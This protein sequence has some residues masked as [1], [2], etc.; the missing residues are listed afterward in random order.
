MCV[1]RERDWAL[2]YKATNMADEKDDCGKVTQKQRGRSRE[3]MRYSNPYRFPA[4]RRQKGNQYKSKQPSTGTCNDLKQSDV[5]ELIPEQP[6]VHPLCSHGDVAELFLAETNRMMLDEDCSY[7]QA[8]DMDRSSDFASEDE[9]NSRISGDEFELLDFADSDDTFEQFVKDED[10]CSDFFSDC[11]DP[12]EIDSECIP[13][14]CEAESDEGLYSG[15]PITSSSSVVLLLSFVFKH[16]LTCEAFNDL[17]A[18]IEA[19]CPR[20]NNCKTTVNKLFQF[21]SQAKGNVV[22]H[23]FCSF[24]KAYFGKDVKGNCNICGKS[25]QNNGGFF[26]EVPIVNQ[27]LNFF[28]GKYIIVFIIIIVIVSIIYCWFFSVMPFKIDQ[29]KKSKPF[30]RLHVSLHVESGNRK[31]VDM[32]RHSP[33]FRSQQFFIWK[34][35]GEMFPQI[36]RDLYRHPML[37]PT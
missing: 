7:L 29:N 8:K 34:I 16:K 11:E 25:I 23:Y 33:R 24:C 27:L 37:V 12:D 1:T 22:K 13:E 17:L 20:P 21:L 30:N 4:A 28:S 3:Y 10:A 31:K 6:H 19:H 35:C 26:I 36:Y 2:D 15:A 14:Q 32:Q 18:V 5:E 9:D